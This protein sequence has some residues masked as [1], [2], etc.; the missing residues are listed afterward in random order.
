MGWTWEVSIWTNEHHWEGEWH[1]HAIYTG[2]N[3]FKALWVFYR[4]KK[5]HSGR[6]VTLIWR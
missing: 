2:E 3:L 4:A 1:Q 6:Y 5:N